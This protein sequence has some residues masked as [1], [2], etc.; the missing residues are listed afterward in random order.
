MRKSTAGVGAVYQTKALKHSQAAS[1]AVQSRKKKMPPA[2]RLAVGNPQGTVQFLKGG[3]I[4]ITGPLAEAIA[5]H[6]KKTAPKAISVRKTQQKV[7]TY[8][9]YS[10]LIRVHN[11][12][13]IVDPRC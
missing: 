5:A 10:A 4:E 7:K 6:C 11:P 2:A 8:Q 1:L 9:V 3:R 12:D 13:V